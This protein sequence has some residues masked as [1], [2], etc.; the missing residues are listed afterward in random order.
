MADLG[1]HV[2]NFQ[3]CNKELSYEQRAK[4]LVRSMTVEEKVVQLGDV[5]YGVKRLGLPPYKWWSEALHGV[6]DV[7]HATKFNKSI[8]GAATNF[9][10]PILSAAAFNESLWKTIGQV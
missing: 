3:F 4:D 9:P 2:K 7:G 1:F 10:V 6:S 8:V 5:A